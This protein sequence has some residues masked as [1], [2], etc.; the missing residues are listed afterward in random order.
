MLTKPQA[1][2]FDIDGV[3]VFQGQTYPGAVDTLAALRAKGLP[4][5]FLTNST[6]KSRASCAQKLQHAGFQVAVEEVITASYATAAYLRPL[7]PRACWVLLDGPGLAEFAEF[8]Q[9]RDDPEYVVVGD[10][11]D[12]FN[13]AN[14]NH[15][16]RLLRRG[17]RLIGM[18]PE[19]L[20]TSS[21]PAEL[22][23][24]AWVELLATAAQVAP[25]YIG[26]PHPFVFELA[27]RTLPCP[28]AAVV[29]VGDRLAT[30]VL[31]AQR[32]G[33]QTVLL[34]TGEFDPRDLPGPVQP[35][36]IFDSI[37]QLADLF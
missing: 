14:L 34:K 16:L 30:D 26:K 13:F 3:L 35:D 24:G 19:L 4:L 28:P 23:V 29:M 18:Q 11:R 5:R 32:C 9:T 12:H 10:Y 17:A 31:G 1:V 25:V 6:L 8:P 2:I 33:L 36:H 15:A 7:H 20:D 22:N 21:G 37:C 27:L